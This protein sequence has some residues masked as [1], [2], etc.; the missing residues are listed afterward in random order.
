MSGVWL[1]RGAVVLSL[2][3]H[4][5]LLAAENDGERFV[6]KIVRIPVVL[7][8]ENAPPPP[9]PPPE[10]PPEKK[11]RPR[12]LAR[13][14][15]KVVAGDGLRTGEIVD[16][17]V[18]EY[19]DEVEAAPPLPPPPPPPPPPPAR[20]P[21]V[22]KA[23]LARTFLEALRGKLMQRK[24]YPVAAQRMGL[25]G[26]VIVSFVVRSD[27]SFSELRVKR[28]SGHDILDSA[29]LETVRG[30]S[31]DIARPP[32]LGDVPLRTSVVLH[33]QLNS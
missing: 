20:K 17:E 28:S 9:P 19:S 2:A 14:I 27:S 32:E 22:D 4:G 3:A 1:F 25:K 7:E 13:S 6:E 23:K 18:G 16:A 30:L 31:G 15:R 5:I 10:E 11:D 26:D 8:T 21:E 24:K 29:A 12:D 33:Y